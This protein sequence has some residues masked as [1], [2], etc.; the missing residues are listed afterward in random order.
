MN[1]SRLQ[2]YCLRACPKREHFAARQL[3]DRT[4][5]E[6]FAPRLAVRRPLRGGAVA[7][8]TEA[9]FPGYLFARFDLEADSR[10][11]ASTPDVTGL[12]RLGAHTPAVPGSL[13]E[14]LRAHASGVQPCAPVLAP[15]DWIQVLSGC[16]A[17]SEG[18]IVTFDSGRSRACVLL[19]LL[20]QELRIDLPAAALRR[21]GPAS[22]DFP[23]QLLASC[24]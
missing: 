15:G 23:P 7:V 20:G 19:A 18:R 1:T 11:V 8:R 21:T 6:A 3:A 17:G 22:L 12:V 10:F 13:I 16:L 24:G 5:I 4:G 2:W 14:L 9:L